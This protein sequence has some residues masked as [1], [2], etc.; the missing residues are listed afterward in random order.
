MKQLFYN[1]KLYFTDREYYHQRKR[2]LKRQKAVRKEL[3]QQAKEF[4]PWSG[5]YMHKMI[6]TM[7][8]FYHATYLAGDCCW[9]EKSGVEEIATCLGVAK[10]W[11]DALD[12]LDDLDDDAV[13]QT[14]QKDAEFEDYVSAWEYKAG[15]TISESNH[16]DSMLAALAYEYLEEKY[17]TALYNIIGK[18]IWEW[19]D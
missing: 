16:P 6:K 14:A 8:E 2:Y 3:K 18:H 12:G 1:I 10:H 4:C 15:A 13:I 17:T 11:S 5:Y 7:L 19:C 9:R